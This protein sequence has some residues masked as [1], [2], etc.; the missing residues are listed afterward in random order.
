MTLKCKKCGLIKQVLACDKDVY[1]SGNDKET[2]F[3]CGGE[4]EKLT[5]NGTQ[6]KENFTPPT[7]NYPEERKIPLSDVIYTDLIEG[8]K[9]NIR[10]LGNDRVLEVIEG[11]KNGQMRLK[12]RK[13]FIEAGG[14][15][16]ISEIK[17]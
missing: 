6:F 15:M 3:I 4:F 2:C 17:I 10:L 7:E 8:M 16:E 1:L 5:D 12:H 14:E 9:K 13:L 11:F